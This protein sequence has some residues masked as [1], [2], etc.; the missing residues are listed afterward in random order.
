MIEYKEEEE[1]DD[2]ATIYL[3]NWQLGRGG[4]RRGMSLLVTLCLCLAVCA[5]VRL[6]V[7]VY[8]FTVALSTATV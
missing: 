4:R 6:S 5:C 1:E 7:C 2:D 3:L 8:W